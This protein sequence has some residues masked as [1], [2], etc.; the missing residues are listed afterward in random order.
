MEGLEITV[1]LGLTILVGT[2]LAPRVRLALPLVLVVF[3]LLL[4]FVPALREV[5]LPPETVLLL[6]LPVMLY[7]ESLTT[8][9]R[10]I[11]RDFRYIL[12][13]STLLV[14]ASAFA[15]AG[16]A[17]LFGLPWEIALILGAAVAPP[18]ATAVAALGRL[19]P[20]R[21][22]MKLKAESLTN[23]GTALVLYAIAVSLA[24]GGQVTPLSVT[25]MVFV[26]YL[27]GIAV[28]VLVAAAGWLL[29]RRM[30]ATITINVTMLLVPFVAFL[31]A[32]MIHASGVLA[33]VV[34][35]LIA[36]YLGP[37]ITTAASR[38]QAESVW[39]FGVFLLNGALFV[40]IG[41][42]VQWVVHQTSLRM[43][44]WLVLATVA[45]WATLLIVRFGF[46]LLSV[47]FQRLGGGSS[48]AAHPRGLRTRAQIVSTV[49]GMRGAISLAI[50]LSV[51]VTATDGSTMTG[52][53]EII[54]VTAGVILLSLLVQGPL[55][56]A[57]VRWAG[58]PVDHAADEEYELAERAITGAA[59]AALDTLASEHD[60]SSEVRDRVRRDGYEM[61]ELANARAMARERALIDAEVG[62]MEDLLDA[63][64]PLAAG[65]EDATSDEL[66]GVSMS[67]DTPSGRTLQMVATSA[68]VDMLQRSPIIRHEEYARLKLAVLEH[69]REVLH[70]LRRAGTV[71]DLIVRN[72][73]A[74]LDLEQLRVQG[75]EPVD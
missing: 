63:P 64:D 21:S 9:L 65:A 30:R 57:V 15:V 59:M 14:V 35:G 43:I 16:V 54:F 48:A 4:G 3:G 74:R 38:R 45:V 41:L 42:E 40:L 25:W 55:L 66:G 17:V 44:G 46:Q 51:P 5:Q 28:G 24:V 32:E 18:D 58:F 53:D 69:E 73:S 47:P 33:V 10:S 56:P 1:L 60:I 19:L 2:M 70:G 8:S 34:A 26:S 52:R 36:A 39:P 27:G 61:L 20:R 11:R 6:F 29:L 71:D 75:M 49:A 68:D 7:W 62:A 67:P 23:D 31:L 50:A 72:I 22:F 12:P 37:R 13:M